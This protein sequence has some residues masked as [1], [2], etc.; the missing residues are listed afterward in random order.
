MK[1]IVKSFLIVILMNGCVTEDY[2]GK[3]DR[4]QIKSFVIP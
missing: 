3:S 2:F 4:S 1:I